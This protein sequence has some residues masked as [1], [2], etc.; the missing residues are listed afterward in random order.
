MLKLQIKEPGEY[1]MINDDIKVVFTEWTRNYLRIMVEA[2]KEVSVVRSKAAEKA[3]KVEP[4]RYLSEKEARRRKTIIVRNDSYNNV[5]E[6][7]A[8]GAAK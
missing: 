2:P 6:Q 4:N 1:I 8:V 7:K 3:G 5:Q